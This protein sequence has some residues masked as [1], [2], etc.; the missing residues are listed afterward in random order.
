MVIVTNQTT[1][2]KQKK[3]KLGSFLLRP[4]RFIV[5]LI[6]LECEKAVK[7]RMRVAVAMEVVKGWY[8]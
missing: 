2:P 5:L 4:Y 3:R 1:E 8:A 6:V 7:R